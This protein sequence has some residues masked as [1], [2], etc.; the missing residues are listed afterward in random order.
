MKLEIGIKSD[1]LGVI[2]ET[3]NCFQCKNKKHG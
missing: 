2:N 1:L 3:V